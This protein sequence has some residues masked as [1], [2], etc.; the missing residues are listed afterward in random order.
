[1][2][3][4]I[5]S[6]H[7]IAM[8][9]FELPQRVEYNG[10]ITLRS[11]I[12]GIGAAGMAL[13]L[14]GGSAW[15]LT[16][17]MGSS[18]CMGGAIAW[19]HYMGMAA[20]HMAA[21]HMPAR[22]KYNI[23]LVEFSVILAMMLSFVALRLVFRLQGGTIKLIRQKLSGALMMG[24][25]I[26]SMHFVGMAATSFVSDEFLPDGMGNS[27]GRATAGANG[28]NRTAL[29]LPMS[30]RDT[31]LLDPSQMALVIGIGV[32]AIL[33]LA[34]AASL[35]DR[36]I[37]VH[38]LR[39]QVLQESEKRFRMLIREMQVGVLLLNSNAEILIR[40]RAA[41]R[42]LSL[43]AEERQQRPSFG[44]GWQL[45]QENG[46]PFALADLPVQRAIALR[47]PIHDVV[48]GIEPDPTHR[49]WL[50]VNADPQFALDGSVERIVCTLSDITDQKQ[51]E[52]ALQKTVER[53][54][55]IARVI[56]QMRQT[57]D[58]DTIFATTT[59]ELRRALNCDRVVIYR[60]HAD[61]SG[62]FVAE[63]VAPL[64]KPLI[65]QHLQHMP[66]TEVLSEGESCAA[67]SFGTHDVPPDAL[68]QDTYLQETQGGSYSRGTSYLCV[69][70]IYRAGFQD[71]YL[72]RL[73]SFQA[74]AYITVPIFC[75]S[76]LWGL[77][78]SYQNSAPRQWEA[79]DNRMM[80]QI[81][82]QLGVAVQQ[83]E[84]FART[85][86]QAKELKTTKENADAA[87]RARANFSPT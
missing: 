34:L 19:T 10:W 74:R 68:S 42:L 39:E 18:V 81:G 37:V 44:L 46:A 64:W 60:F 82:T 66:L 86:Q 28:A 20:M 3:T 17:L 22:V 15:K 13:G 27:L 25:A 73:E 12:Y 85:Q 47:Q 77:L 4:G 8:L 83:A 59:Q 40:N 52:T 26:S 7:F 62:E 54:Q 11:L 58:L 9:A 6:T 87:N 41:V 78:A 57:L 61:W 35:F 79:A 53:E 2:G 38:L 21:I 72:Q 69:P 31:A 30:G 51:A 48:I 84:L 33:V 1:M 67:K 23:A 24:L 65:Q 32:I 16:R 56:Q 71:C 29:F 75:G 36:Y 50:L 43:S 63:S 55:A 80:T 76:K 5:W 49:Y 45:L 14:L 70:D